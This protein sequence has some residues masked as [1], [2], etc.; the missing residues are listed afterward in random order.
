MT[1]IEHDFGKKTRDTIKRF[2]E[3][4]SLEAKH[5]ASVQANPIPYLERANERMSQ[6]EM[7]ILEA[8]RAA[9]IGEP[10][11]PAPNEETV[12]VNKV[13]YERLLRC[14]EILEIA[15]AKL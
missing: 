8:A 11:S 5:E 6:L 7:T 2:T 13:E 15:Q 14:K 12:T 9:T 10:G 3:L 4:M 1:I